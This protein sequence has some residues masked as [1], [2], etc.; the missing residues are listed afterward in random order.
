[1]QVGNLIRIRNLS[2]SSSEK[3]ILDNISLNI[4]K[5]KITALI[6]PSGIGKTTLLRLIAGQLIPDSG[7]IWF[8]NENIPS[9]S[10]NKLYQV[11]KKMSMLF[12]SNALFTDLSVFDNI[13][14]PLRK[15]TQLDEELIRTLVLLK[16]ESVSL[17]PVANLMPNELSGGMARRVALARSIALDP[18][19]IMYDEPFVGQDPIMMAVLMKL[20]YSLNH[21]LGMTSVLVSHDIA[22]VMSIANWVYLL[23]DGK[24]IAKGSPEELRNNSNMYVQ[25]FLQGI[26]MNSSLTYSYHTAINIE[27]DLFQSC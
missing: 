12:Q 13:A 3:K 9:L 16:L 24:V 22:E 26:F 2:F 8:C 11:R 20:I 6:G 7:E 4:P 25:N 19:L 21:A 27:K 1:M 17:R 5:G 18:Y 23:V 15:H 14:F 10:R